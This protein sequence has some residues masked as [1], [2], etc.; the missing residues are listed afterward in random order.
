MNLIYRQVIFRI[1][2]KYILI[3]IVLAVCIIS[4]KF[5]F[6]LGIVDLFI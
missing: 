4:V 5:S 1:G 6:W 3:N 2:V